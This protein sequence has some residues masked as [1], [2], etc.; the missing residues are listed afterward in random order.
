MTE[1]T[2]DRRER[3]DSLVVPEERVLAACGETPFPETGVIEQVY[4][5]D[6]VADVERAAAAAVEALPIDGR[7]A[8]DGDAASVAVGVGSRGIANLPALV[9]GVVGALAAAGHEP[10]VVPAMGSHG[11]AT[12]DGQREL[13][14]ELGVTPETV[15]CE[16]RASMSV[17]EVGRT[18]QRDVPVVT[19]AAAAEADAILPINRVKPH[20]DYDGPVESGL[21]KMLTIG[22]G[23][24]RGA[25]IAHE[26]G[27]DWSLSEMVP[28]IAER[29]IEELPVVGGVAV[30][31]D[32][33]DDTAL[34]E[35]VPAGDPLDRERELLEIATERMPTL[36]FDDL[37]VLVLDRQGKEIS[38]QGADPNVT[39]RR[40]FS[41][42]EPEPATPSVDRIYVR[43]LTAATHG[44][45]MGVG[46]A[47]LIHADLL[48]AVDAPTTLVNALTAST[49]RGVR[50]PPA[51]ATDR[52][53]LTA[54]LSTAGAV[55]PDAVRL[56]HAADTS[57][58]D[59]LHASAALVAAARDRADLRV[60]EEPSPV[61]FEDGAFATTPADRLDGE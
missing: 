18:P 51:V 44:N 49:V 50:L 29:L 61:A 23:K 58:L 19:A 26:R 20:T 53:G 34:V 46:S 35:G 48:A 54:A 27:V 11:G 21:A 9:R 24:Q 8:H 36:P 43:G 25:K 7:G 5:T 22:F 30:V 60:V 1:D 59:R 42:G 39:G 3:R 2:T 16:I 47:D 55:E 31:E 38:G 40:P 15:G 41:L 17:V 10:F 33:R 6:P 4:D 32:E 14:A 52:A 28:L 57:H 56:L 13:L 12:A 45:A 37:D